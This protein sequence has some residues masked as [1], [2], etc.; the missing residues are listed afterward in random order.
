MNRHVR[1]CLMYDAVHGYLL[2]AGIIITTCCS[3]RNGYVMW[4]LYGLGNEIR[5]DGPSESCIKAFASLFVQN[6]HSFLPSIENA[7]V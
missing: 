2:H 1:L 7:V 4:M 3:A 6:L 5:Y